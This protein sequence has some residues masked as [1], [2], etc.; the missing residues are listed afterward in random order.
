MAVPIPALVSL[1]AIFR[2][3]PY[4]K[5]R[6][7]SLS[8]TR[9]PWG[10][11]TKRRIWALLLPSFPPSLRLPELFQLG[12]GKIPGNIHRDSSQTSSCVYRGKNPLSSLGVS[13]GIHP[14][15]TSLLVG[16]QFPGIWEGFI[17]QQAGKE[18]WDEGTGK[19]CPFP[20]HEDVWNECLGLFPGNWGDL[21]PR[22]LR[23]ISPYKQRRKFGMNSWGYSQGIWEGIFPLQ[24]GEVVWDESLVPARKFPI[25]SWLECSHPAQADV[26]HLEPHPCFYG[27]WG[28]SAADQAQ[29]PCWGWD[30]WLQIPDFGLGSEG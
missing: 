4:F 25:K 10:I 8:D 18:V 15:P 24:A 19:N 5:P 3:I 12:Q 22:K 28:I 13:P 26:G 29:G 30:C 6:V 2:I 1:W 9:L 20:A 17:P 27:I 16:G 23:E 7:K 11:Y 21:S 14:K